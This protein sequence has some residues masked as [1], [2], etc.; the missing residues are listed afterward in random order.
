MKRKEEVERRRKLEEEKRKKEKA[1]TTLK[2]S[3]K[4]AKPA[5][6]FTSE[7]CDVL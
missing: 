3:V 6:S 5:V 1:D 4:I 2:G 7:E